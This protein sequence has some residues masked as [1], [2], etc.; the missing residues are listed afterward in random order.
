MPLSL[1]LPLLA[2]Q[3][4]FP[5]G[6]VNE[7]MVHRVAL[8]WTAPLLS[9]QG[10]SSHTCKFHI[11]EGTRWVVENMLLRASEREESPETGVGEGIGLSGGNR[12]Q[13]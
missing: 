5:G 9:S 2:A 1:L 6:T 7:S 13:Q 11:L 10:E 3:A 12:L 8:L 4:A